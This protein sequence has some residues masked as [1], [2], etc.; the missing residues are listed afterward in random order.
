MPPRKTTNQNADTPFVFKGANGVIKI[1]GN[2]T[3]DPDANA[4]MALNDALEGGGSELAQVS[5]TLRMILSGFPPEVRKGINLKLSEVKDFSEQFMA[6]AGVDL[7][8]S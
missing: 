6:H 7:P 3:F 1:P 2:V 4:A 5:A 8:K